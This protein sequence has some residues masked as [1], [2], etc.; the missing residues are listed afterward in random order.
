[1]F[2][3]KM[4]GMDDILR[5]NPDL[6]RQMAQA[7]ASQAVGP[8]FANFVSM[9]MP[10]GGMSSGMG[11]GM[12]GM[13]G[14]PSAGQM[15]SMTP[16][17]M[18]Y[19]EE[20]SRPMSFM[21]PMGSG[22]GAPIPNMDPRGGVDMRE[23]PVTARREMRGPSGVDDILRTLNAN[24]DMPQRAVPQT[25][26][27]DADEI[28]SVTSGLTTETM[29]RNGINRKRKATTTQPTGATLTLNI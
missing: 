6:A 8:G 7:A 16:P 26:G 15:G 23:G 13:G 9:G 1:M 14:R 4:P 28:N 3:S 2:K 19:E 22:M 29:R 21:P 24:G 5:K 11:G 10:G 25:A 12:G 27:I 20:E 18:N 17:S